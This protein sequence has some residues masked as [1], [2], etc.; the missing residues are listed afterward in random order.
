MKRFFIGLGLICTILLIIVMIVLLV[1]ALKYK[2][3]YKITDSIVFIEVTG[4]NLEKEGMGFVY[5]TVDDINYIVT[6]YHVVNSSDTIYV[7][8]LENDKTRAKLVTFDAYTDI[9]VIKIENKLDL[10]DI[11]IG[12][13]IVKVNDDAYYFNINKKEIGKASI[14]SL[15]S[16]ININASYGNSLYKVNSIDGDIVLGNSG[17]PLFNYNDE[18]IG[19][20]SLK[21][22]NNDSSFYMTISY[23]MDIVNKLENKSL[24]R[25]N[26]GAM[27]VNTTNTEFL[28]KYGITLNEVNGVVV[29]DL[30]ENYPLSN[31]GFINGDVITK[32]NDI[33]IDNV[34]TL[35]KEIY[36]YKQNDVVRIEYNRNNSFNTVDVVLN[37]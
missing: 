17:S 12:N 35:Q 4:K 25:P 23:V 11:K 29:L 24:F 30:K 20:I 8:N 31:S 27:M 14:L 16:E 10:E 34:S 18:V 32:V 19:M 7:R 5:K 2:Q 28:N 33:V 3:E 21:E 36:S 22:E 1:F 37:K 13:D 6:N 26:L 9:A 15:D